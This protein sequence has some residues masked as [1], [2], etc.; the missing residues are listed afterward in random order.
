M[1]NKLA[2]LEFYCHLSDCHF[3]RMVRRGIGKQSVPPGTV[4]IHP[5]D[6]SSLDSTFITQVYTNIGQP[7]YS[8]DGGGGIGIGSKTAKF[9]IWKKLR[10]LFSILMYSRFK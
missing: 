1:G 2:G 10:N 7:P 4:D 3:L 8:K 9:K 6:S 5:R